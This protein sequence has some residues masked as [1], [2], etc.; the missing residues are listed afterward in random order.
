MITYI[1]KCLST[2]STYDTSSSIAQNV[3]F[4]EINILK[5]E[6]CLTIINSKK[7]A[8]QNLLSFFWLKKLH[9]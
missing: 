8:K 9:I 6:I 7:N 4:F 2:L 1:M 3:L 5:I